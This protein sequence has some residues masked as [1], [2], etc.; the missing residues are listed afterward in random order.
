ML[1]RLFISAQ[2]PVSDLRHSDM[3]G[4]LDTLFRARKQKKIQ[5]NSRVGHLDMHPC[6]TWVPESEQHRDYLRPQCKSLKIEATAAV[7]E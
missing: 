7:R 5:K 4:H 6:Q 1:L 2:V 3:V